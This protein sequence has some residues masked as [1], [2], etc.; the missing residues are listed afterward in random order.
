[1]ENKADKPSLSSHGYQIIKTNHLEE[2]DIFRKDLAGFLIERFSLP[3]Q[4]ASLILNNIHKIANID[5]DR[6]ANDLVLE[7]INNFSTSYDFAEIAYK[8]YGEQIEKI[9]GPDLHAQ[10]NNNIVFQYPNSSRFSELHTDSPPNSPYEIVFW[11]PLV[12]CYE[13]KSFFVLPI[14]ESKNLINKYKSNN[15]NN[16]SDFKKES[17][18]KACH[19][20]VDYSEALLFWT[21]IMHGSLNNQTN[22]SRWCLNVRFKNLFTPCGQHDPLTYYRVFRTSIVSNL[23]FNHH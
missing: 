17:L 3:N 4:E 19:V 5:S 2:L 16:W 20:K 8:L 22:E 9:L 15:F 6:K 7:V 11:I 21:G 14:E 23:A 10:R 18:S 12:N 1:M 13:S